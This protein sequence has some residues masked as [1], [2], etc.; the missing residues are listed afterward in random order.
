MCDMSPV[1]KE[2]AFKKGIQKGL[3]DAV[4]E[5]YPYHLEWRVPTHLFI[6][7]EKRSVTL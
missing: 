7:E 6:A 1:L 5:T 4:T 2:L 3:S